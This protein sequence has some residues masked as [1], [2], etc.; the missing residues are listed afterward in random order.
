MKINM[1]TLKS[2]TLIW[3]LVWATRYTSS[4]MSVDELITIDCKI[5]GQKLITVHAFD[6]EK[7]AAAEF[8][9]ATQEQ[10]KRMRILQLPDNEDV[11]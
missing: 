7:E 9:K 4:S 1:T 8:A 11:R 10:Q 5:A 3:I 2:L 6:T